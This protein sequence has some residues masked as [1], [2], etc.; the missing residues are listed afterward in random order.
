M[1]KIIIMILGIMLISSMLLAKTKADKR[2]KQ[3]SMKNKPE[4]MAD[5]EMHGKNMIDELKLTPE[6]KKKFENLRAEHQKLMNSIQADTRNL[7]I[8]LQTA[9][10]ADNFKRAKELNKQIAAK[11]NQMMD[12]RIDHLEAMLKELTAEQ[13]EKAKEIFPRMMMDN[14]MMQG[15]NREKG[16]KGGKGMSHCK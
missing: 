3:H 11:Q 4:A 6:Q 10:K 8:D 2:D 16:M 1:R 5:S 14:N 9:I 12:A 13:K 15:R 7:N